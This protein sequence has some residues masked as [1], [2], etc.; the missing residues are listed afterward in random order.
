MRIFVLIICISTTMN[1]QV[2]FD[3]SKATSLEAW[4]VVDD[5]VMGG[6]S[7]GSLH[8]DSNGY[9]FFSG[10]VSLENNGGFSSIRCRFDAIKIKPGAKVVITSKGDGKR[11][12]FRIKDR[13]G[14]FY[15]Y[16]AYFKSSET[17]SE[18]V[19]PLENMYPTF[20]GQ[21]LNQ[22]NFD[23]TQIEEIAFLIANKEN[24]Q[25]QLLIKKV[26]IVDF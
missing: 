26:E 9:G 14:N 18:V 4:T 2:L 11:Y 7:A 16:I 15:S 8:L 1:A 21:R 19:I 3:F 13:S 12:Q 5:V 6:E 10:T 24:E 17:W 20:R 23:H 25:F 22:P